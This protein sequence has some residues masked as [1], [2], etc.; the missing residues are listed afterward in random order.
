MLCILTCSA[1]NLTGAFSTEAFSPRRERGGEPVWNSLTRK[2]RAKRRNDSAE[3]C[4]LCRAQTD[5]HRLSIL[6]LLKANPMTACRSFIRFI[7]GS[8]TTREPNCIVVKVLAVGGSRRSRS[9]RHSVSRASLAP[10]FQGSAD[11]K[12]IPRSVIPTMRRCYGR[13]GNA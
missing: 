1:N 6:C 3:A 4:A 2:D 13:C 9:A 10:K 7:H 12:F 11:L 5:A 8:G